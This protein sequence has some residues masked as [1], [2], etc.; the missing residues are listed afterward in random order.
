MY[1]PYITNQCMHIYPVLSFRLGSSKC[2]LSVRHL[3]VTHSSERKRMSDSRSVVLG[4][5]LQDFISIVIILT[6]NRPA[7]GMH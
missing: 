4:Y 3:A 7:S 1:S 6:S 5:I 2:E